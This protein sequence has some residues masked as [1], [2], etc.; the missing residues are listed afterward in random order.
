[1]LLKVDMIFDGL[2]INKMKYQPRS[3]DMHME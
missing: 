1:M 2:M 3:Y